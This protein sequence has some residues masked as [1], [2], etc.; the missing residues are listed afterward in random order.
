[1]GKTLYLLRHAK[2]SWEDHTL[3]DHDRPL[4]PPGRRASK[5]I[6]EY[7]R[8]Q[9]FAL[10]I[11]RGDESRALRLERRDL[12]GPRREFRWYRLW[13]RHG[14]GLQHVVGPGLRRSADGVQGRR[15]AAVALVLVK[16][17]P[18][19]DIDFTCL[20]TCRWGDY[21]GATSDPAASL[22]GTRGR[23]WLTNEWNVASATDKDVD[24]R[25]WIWSAVP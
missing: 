6:A 19:P 4:A 10:P 23:V 24:A 5:A 16:Q 7:L 17:S 22:S 8:R 13:P 14:D 15:S 12:A 9:P 11:R 20:Q 1:M 18:G 2:S 3:A 21:S 25:T